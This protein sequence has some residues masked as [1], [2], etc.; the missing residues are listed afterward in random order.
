MGK[1]AVKK[2]STEGKKKAS[3]KASSKTSS[4]KEKKGYSKKTV[5]RR[6]LRGQVHVKCSYNNT[7]ITVTDQSG[8]VLGWASAGSLGF[9]GAKKATP[10]AATVVCNKAIENVARTGLKEADV[11]VKGVGAGREAS[12]RSLGNNG[13]KVGLIKDVTPVPHNGCR[14]KKAR[15]V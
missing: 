2:D 11:F 8:S 10:Y 5:K 12:I 1:E 9:K 4:S 13:I 15:R 7:I 14:S 3:V 6:V